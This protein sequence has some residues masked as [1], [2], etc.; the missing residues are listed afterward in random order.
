MG[1]SQSTAA[2]SGC[3]ARSRASR[4]RWRATSSKSGGRR[5]ATAAATGARERQ[6]FMA[7]HRGTWPVVMMC[8]A[9]GVSRSGFY[10]WL[11]RPRSQRSLALCR[12]KLPHRAR[13]CLKWTPLLLNFP[14]R[15]QGRRYP[16]DKL[17]KGCLP[18]GRLSMRAA[19]MRMRVTKGDGR[20]V[21]APR[22]SNQRSALTLK[23]AAQKWLPRLWPGHP[24]PELPKTT[25]KTHKLRR[26]IWKTPSLNSKHSC[27]P[28][29]AKTSTGAAAA[30]RNS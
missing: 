27:R 14:P 29:T 28:A 4:Q 18:R 11:S 26:I 7:K 15:E 1:L 30:V 21:R 2:S 6:S 13:S 5:C 12:V 3:I 20:S 8:E 25:P 23:R 17:L 19:S 16:P 22:P 10:A 9:L 24:R